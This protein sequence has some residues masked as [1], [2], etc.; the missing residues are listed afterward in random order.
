MNKNGKPSTC[1]SDNPKMGQAY[2]VK[3]YKDGGK[4]TDPMDAVDEY[5]D[6][7]AKDYRL[8][9]ARPGKPLNPEDYRL[10]LARPG[11]PVEMQKL[12]LRFKDRD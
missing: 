7:S 1:Y 12:P 5:L 4:V 11:K 2:P 3:G 10:P 8:P 6:K 9:R